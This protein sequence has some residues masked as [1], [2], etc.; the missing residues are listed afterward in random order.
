MKKRIILGT[1]DAAWSTSCLS[2][3]PSI[4]F[5]RLT[6]FRT[7]HLT[8]FLPK[9]HQKI[10]IQTNWSE[11]FGGIWGIFGQ[12]TAPVLALCIPCPWFW[13]FDCFF[14]Y[15]NCWFSDLKHTNSKKSSTKVE[16]PPKKLHTYWQL[17]FFSLCSP[18]Y[19]KQPTTS[20][21]FYEFFYP[22]TL[23]KSSRIY[24][25]QYTFPIWLLNDDNMLGEHKG[26]EKSI[27][28]GRLF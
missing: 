9:L 4:L 25:G 14:F 16:K 6:D 23:V 3:R 15:N 28:Y 5:W 27:A 12:T 20:F 7:L 24:T 2:H 22:T 21:P 18:D 13:V 10:Q 8:C 17:G 11:N 1:S 26:G 19:P